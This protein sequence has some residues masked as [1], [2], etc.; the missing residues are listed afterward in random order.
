MTGESTHHDRLDQ[1]Q[2]SWV[3]RLREPEHGAFADAAALMRFHEVDEQGDAAVVRELGP[4]GE[5]RAAF[6]APHVGNRAKD[7]TW[8][9]RSLTRSIRST[10]S[11]N[12]P[13]ARPRRVG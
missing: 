8:E 5:V 13:V 4:S 12:K 9:L 2:R 11:T 7:R 1:V 10:R 3:V 6:F